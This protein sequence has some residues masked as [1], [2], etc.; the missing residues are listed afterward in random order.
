M[1]SILIV[2]DCSCYSRILNGV[3]KQ[4]WSQRMGENLDVR[5]LSGARLDRK[6]T[7]TD[8]WAGNT[9]IQKLETLTG[10]GSG[11]WSR[12]KLSKEESRRL[13]EQL[14][15]YEG[16][17]QRASSMTQRSVVLERFVPWDTWVVV[18]ESRHPETVSDILHALGEADKSA[19]YDPN[20]EVPRVF[21]PAEVKASVYKATHPNPQKGFAF[22]YLSLWKRRWDHLL[23]GEIAIE[24]LYSLPDGSRSSK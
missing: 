10:S 20:L 4:W 22:E 23:A 11:R 17:R 12:G 13:L 9:E 24:M 19:S 8:D 6:Y 15:T 7:I 3:R 1:A 5:L 21:S 14:K 16:V 2:A 18:D